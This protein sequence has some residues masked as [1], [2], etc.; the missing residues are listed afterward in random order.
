MSSKFCCLCG[1]DQAHVKK[2]IMGIKGAVCV[3]CVALC[4][5]ILAAD[6]RSSAGEAG[7]QASKYRTQ[8]EVVAPPGATG[9]SQPRLVHDNGEQ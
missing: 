8:P 4:A 7:D 9:D 2:L 6:V 5:N 3:D 1:E